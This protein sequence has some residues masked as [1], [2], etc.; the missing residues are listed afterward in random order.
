MRSRSSTTRRLLTL[1]AATSVMTLS[2]VQSV[3]AVAP[4]TT[5]LPT[6]SREVLTP[7]SQTTNLAAAWTNIAPNALA[8]YYTY[9]PYTP[10]NA[11][12]AGFPAALNCGAVTA[13]AIIGSDC[14]TVMV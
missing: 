5:Y 11:L 12:I 13:G 1:L 3:Y 7:A 10:A 14:L 6:Y 2:A 4:Y 8:S 9:V